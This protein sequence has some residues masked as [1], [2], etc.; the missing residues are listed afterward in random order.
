MCGVE[1]QLGH[2]QV[3]RSRGRV[4]GYRHG[5]KLHVV[6]GAGCLREKEDGRHLLWSGHPWRRCGDWE[7]WR[8]Q[9]Q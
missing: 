9:D 1:C 5:R 3:K 2:F 7:G 8:E 4:G 6:T